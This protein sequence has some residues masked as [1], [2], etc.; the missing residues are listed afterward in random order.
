MGD[1]PR[2]LKALGLFVWIFIYAAYRL[3]GSSSSEA[4]HGGGELLDTNPKGSSRDFSLGVA[5]MTDAL[6]ISETR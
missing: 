2:H 3:L 4:S 6:N 5:E 1:K